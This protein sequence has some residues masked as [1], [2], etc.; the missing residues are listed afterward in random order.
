MN[1][2]TTAAEKFE[3]LYPTQDPLQYFANIRGELTNGRVLHEPEY[4]SFLGEERPS[5]KSKQRPRSM[6]HERRPGL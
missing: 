6:E 3:S 4:Y 1:A 5:S 2:D